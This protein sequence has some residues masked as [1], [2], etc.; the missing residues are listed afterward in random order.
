[1][2][3]LKLLSSLEE[4]VV[5]VALW[6]VLLPRT[7]FSAIFTPVKLARYFDRT[8]DIP[9]KERDDEYLSPV[10][11]W[12][13]LGPVSLIVLFMLQDQTALAIYGADANERILI[14][15]LMLIG[16]P[17]GF[18]L[19]S[20][21]VR[22]ESVSRRSLGRQFALQCYFN[23]PVAFLFI[24]I[25]LPFQKQF[26]GTLVGGALT[27]IVFLAWMWLLI[28]EFRVARRESEVERAVVSA[29]MGCGF[30]LLLLLLI[31]FAVM[32]ALLLGGRV[33]L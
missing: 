30:A 26:E 16:P 21:V 1:M 14:A 15:A 32:F 6:I 12:L 19:A 2:N 22:R 27:S 29:A 10:L 18:A 24:T 31:G 5:E 3:F 8:H 33:T 13:L 25:F 4:L 7:L 9:L 20:V 23:A 17:L 11:F 28:T